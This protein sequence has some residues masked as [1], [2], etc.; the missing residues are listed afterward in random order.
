MAKA[1]TTAK[2][3]VKKPSAQLIDGENSR[4]IPIEEIHNLPAPAL[5]QPPVQVTI[6]QK[7]AQEVARFDVARS[8]I[9]EKK[10]AYKALSIAGIDDKEGQKA[11]KEAWQEIRNKRLDVDKSHKA[12]KGDYL[13]ITQAIDKEKRE[14]TELLEEIETPLKSELDRIEAE[15]EAIKQKAEREAQAK[16]QGR[17]TEL[18]N[19]GMAFNGNYYAIG[20]TISMDVV[21]LKNMN[22]EDYTT[23]LG[24]VQAENAAIV[25]AQEEKERKEREDREALEKQRQQQIEQQRQLEEQQR[26]LK[27][28]QEEIDRQKREAKEA[29]TKARSYMLEALGMF[30]SYADTG[31]QFR[32]ADCG[33]VSILRAS[34][35]NLEGAEWESELDNIK[36]QV[37]FTKSLQFEKDQE[38]AKQERESREKAEKER[39]QAEARRY[40]IVNR[41]AEIFSFGLIEYADGSFKRSFAYAEIS[42]LIITKSQLE[43]YDSPSWEKEIANLKLD[44]ENGLKMESL[45][46]Q[47][48]AVQAEAER[49]AALSD[50]DRVN[51]WLR[52]FGAAMGNKPLITDSKLAQAFA[53]F[54]R[55]VAGAVEDLTLVLDNIE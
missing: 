52:D 19:N 32:T 25:A 1:T 31:W 54:D 46:K 34:V 37:K 36:N 3:S 50:R 17:V 9:A 55:A 30:Y 18:L 38:K 7:A 27:A 13:K 22:D 44:L 20:A 5:I 14:L 40:M 53:S 10:E 4:D 21:T 35:E 41:T 42:P 28:Q 47:R 45:I 15:K 8:W 51:E 43:N 6:E 39:Q 48:L 24:R 2:K 49:Q 33:T 16:L 26:Q 23:F 12:I 11:V 29:R